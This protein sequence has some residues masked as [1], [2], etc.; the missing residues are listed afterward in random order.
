MR[1]NY[2]IAYDIIQPKRL[3]KV[4]DIAYSYALGGQKSA[5]EAPLDKGELK[6]ICE[7]FLSII[8]KGDKINIIMI[9][10]NPILLGKAKFIDMD[11]D[12]III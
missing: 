9:E 1:Q 7:K 2:L 8:K 3:R 4:K 12:F 11:E 6:S 5:V 10:D